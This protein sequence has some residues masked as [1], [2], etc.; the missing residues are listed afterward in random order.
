MSLHR[1][2]CPCGDC[3][4]GTLCDSC[5]APCADVDQPAATAQIS[6]AQW[7]LYAA[8]VPGT[9]TGWVIWVNGAYYFFDGTTTTCSI[10]RVNSINWDISYRADSCPDFSASVDVVIPFVGGWDFSESSTFAASATGVSNPTACAAFLMIGASVTSAT[11]PT[12]TSW[13]VGA[14]SVGP[15]AVELYYGGTFSYTPGGGLVVT[16]CG[17][18]FIGTDGTFPTCTPPG[19]GLTGFNSTTI[20]AP[21]LSATAIMDNSQLSACVLRFAQTCSTGTYSVD[22]ETADA[23]GYFTC[24]VETTCVLRFIGPV[25]DFVDMFNGVFAGTGIT[26]SALETDWFLGAKVRAPYVGTADQ[27]TFPASDVS[28]TSF[29]LAGLGDTQD[30]T[31]AGTVYGILDTDGVSV[32]DYRQIIC[33]VQF[34]GKSTLTLAD[35]TTYTLCTDCESTVADPPLQMGNATSFYAEHATQETGATA[36]SGLIRERYGVSLA[37]SAWTWTQSPLG[38]TTPDE[39]P[40]YLTGLSFGVT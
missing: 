25:S 12:F 22:L 3:Y 17:S 19:S 40:C 16:E 30:V 15:S 4:E 20:I 24:T 31:L 14:Q 13:T 7:D 9:G 11:A 28:P 1:S 5:L 21:E 38:Y 2:C 27:P 6:A 10:P 33:G 36:G 18:D 32:T 35:T 8:D 26:V 34:Y 23:D 37:P 29:G 39:T